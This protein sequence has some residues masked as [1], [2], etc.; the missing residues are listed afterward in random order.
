MTETVKKT[1]KLLITFQN[2]DIEKL[3]VPEEDYAALYHALRGAEEVDAEGNKTPS[4]PWDSIVFATGTKLYRFSH[5]RKVD[6][7]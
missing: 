2:G 5:V 7:V 1:K 6:F 4:K 3:Q